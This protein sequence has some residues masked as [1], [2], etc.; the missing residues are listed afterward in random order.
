MDSCFLDSISQAIW[1]F[2]Q[3]VILFDFFEFW[4]YLKQQKLKISKLFELAICFHTLSWDIGFKVRKYLAV[5]RIS[6]KCFS[7]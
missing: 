7:I 4:S 1:N 5:I 2:T 3:N 6:C